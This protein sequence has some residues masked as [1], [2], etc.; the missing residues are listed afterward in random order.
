MRFTRR[1]IVSL[2]LLSSLNSGITE[3]SDLSE[4]YKLAAENDHTFKA[5]EARFQAG[6][7]AKKRQ[8]AGLLPSLNGSITYNDQSSE[9]EI[10]GLS[11]V[12]GQI[13]ENPTQISDSESTGY[14]LSL[15]VPLFDLGAWHS[16]KAGSAEANSA[17]AIFRQQEQSLIIRSAEAYFNTLLAA[18]NL[19]TS[20]AEETALKQ[21]LTQSQQR[22]E[23]GLN[24]ITEVHEAQ[25][26][27]D[28]AVA[29]RLTTEGQLG[30][31][32][33]ALEVLTGQ[34]FSSISPLKEDFPVSNPAPIN[35]EDWVERAISSNYD[36]KAASAV[37]KSAKAQA[38]AAKAG[39]L[40]TLSLNAQYS[41][42]TIDSSNGAA[43]FDPF[44]QSA[45]QENESI[46]LTLS[47]PLY[48]GGSV[49]S[50][51][52]RSKHNAIIERENYLQAKRDIIQQ[53]RSEHLNVITG[54]ATVKAR[55][56]T[57][58]SR[59]SALEA[60]EAGYRVGTRDFVDVLN[61]Q[62]GLFQ[63]KR[64]YDQALYSYVLSSLRL[65][66]VAGMLSEEDID[67]LNLWLDS[68]QNVSN[69]NLTY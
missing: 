20:L 26:S 32:F 60:T 12:A 16:Y 52:R 33:E 9:S 35:R 40:P 39:H 54:V 29:D 45:D 51:R 55:K 42:S 50:E 38:R 68:E 65:K 24:A 48:N 18:A 3:A 66:N 58:I 44:V 57:I 41:D 11:F 30:I 62:R 22:Y 17:K 4:V 10:E 21:Q 43:G 53:T 69:V 14:N 31:Q 15:S 6:L 37:A 25:A 23:V 8:R 63:A 56:Q 19:Q 67:A 64:D 2:V 49:S 59:Q 28:S 34:S 27:Y 47:V 13:V 61:A 5:A 1:C 36:L 7:E 46:N